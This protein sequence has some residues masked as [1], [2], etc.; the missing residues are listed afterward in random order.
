[1][2]IAWVSSLPIPRTRPRTFAIDTTGRRERRVL[3]SITSG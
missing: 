3:V 1:M 2:S